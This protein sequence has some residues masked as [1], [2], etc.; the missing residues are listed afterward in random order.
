MSQTDKLAAA[1]LTRSDEHLGVLV[2][3]ADPAHVLLC[4]SVSKISM[5]AKISTK[6]GGLV[7]ASSSDSGGGELVAAAGLE[8]DMGGG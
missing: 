7:S 3:T 6:P 8:V 2:R 1:Q 4:E 5:D